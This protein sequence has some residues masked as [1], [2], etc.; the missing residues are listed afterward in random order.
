M[1]DPM[2]NPPGLNEQNI[3]SEQQIEDGCHNAAG[4]LYEFIVDC[5]YTEYTVLSTSVTGIGCALTL[6]A[7]VNLLLLLR[8]AGGW[9]GLDKNIRTRNHRT[10]CVL[11]IVGRCT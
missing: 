4:H 1:G 11:I 6:L 5:R 9:R 3:T 7:V 10:C 8:R 2:N